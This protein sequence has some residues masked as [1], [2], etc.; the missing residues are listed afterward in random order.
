MNELE[1]GSE[2]YLSKGDKQVFKKSLKEIFSYEN[3]RF[4]MTGRAALSYALSDANNKIKTKTAYLPAYICESVI[5][6]FIF[7]SSSLEQ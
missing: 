3:S 5:N 7:F 6:C 4:L 1:I 2:F